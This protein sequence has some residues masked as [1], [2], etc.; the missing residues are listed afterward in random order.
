MCVHVSLCRRPCA[1][2][3]KHVLCGCV[4][5]QGMCSHLQENLSV[6]ARVRVLACFLL[7][8][9][10]VL[11]KAEARKCAFHAPPTLNFQGHE[12]GAAHCILTFDRDK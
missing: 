11:G 1:R 9:P 8:C 3:P 12:E 7:P 2:V 5:V 4:C 10:R 6:H